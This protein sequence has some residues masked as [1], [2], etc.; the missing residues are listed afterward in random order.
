MVTV[1]YVLLVHCITETLPG[2][3]KMSADDWDHVK[4]DLVGIEESHDE[5]ADDGDCSG[6]DLALPFA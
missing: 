1:D 6:E 2:K 5:Q 4:F 3:L